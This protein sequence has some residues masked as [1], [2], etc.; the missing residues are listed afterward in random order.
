MSSNS[1]PKSSV[2]QGYS[3]AF[4]TAAVLS[5]TGILIRYLTET[6][7]LPALVLAFWREAFVVVTLLTLL[8]VLRPSLI[9]VERRH[10]RYLL[11]FGLVLAGFNAIWTLSVSLNGA[12]IA[13]V[14]VFSSAALTALLG[15]WLLKER[16]DWVKVVAILA[17]LAGCVLVSDALNEASRSANLV[18]IVAGLLSGLGYAAYSLMGRSAS[19]RGLN[20]WTTLLY[21][22]G[23][24]SLF[25]LGFNLQPWIPLP[26]TAA[27][28]AELLWL[29]RSWAGWAILFILAAGPT[30]GG[31]GLWNV[32]LTYLPASV[33]NLVAT[34]EPV[35]TAIVAYL[36]LHERLT[37][38]Q[39][40]GSAL[41]LAGVAF[42][43]I[44][45]GW[46][47][48]RAKALAS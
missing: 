6:Y 40:L 19:Q 4:A 44:Y 17:S 23:F 34:V 13:T 12:A 11:V 42:L 37:G 14:L 30:L 25:M 45:D 26:G 29:G 47:E 22:F 35:F 48:K 36:F 15:R 9:R 10:L 39:I 7:A 28:P 41:I 27:A 21:A 1:N 3:I 20:P 31:Y 32:A 46:L 38:T 8:L 33:V 2:S 18:G 16:L 43:R 5:L 24:G